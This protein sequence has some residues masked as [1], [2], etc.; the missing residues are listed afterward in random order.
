MKTKYMVKVPPTMEQG[1][2]SCKAIDRKD[3]LWK[4][5]SARAHDGL[6]PIERMPNGTRYT[7][8]AN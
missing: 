5:N 1:S 6:E 3:A 8:E 4:Y 7:K 2:Y